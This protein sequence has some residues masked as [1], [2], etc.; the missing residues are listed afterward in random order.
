MQKNRVKAL[1][2]D[3]KSLKLGNRF[4]GFL[5]KCQSIFGQGPKGAGELK[6]LVLPSS[7][8][9]WEQTHS[10]HL[11]PRISITLIY[12]GKH[13]PKGTGKKTAY[14]FPSFSGMYYQ[15]TL[16]N[17]FANLF[18]TIVMLSSFTC[19]FD[20]MKQRIISNVQNVCRWL[21]HMNEDRLIHSG[22]VNNETERGFKTLC[23]KYK[24]CS[25]WP[26]KYYWV[27]YPRYWQC[28]Y[29]LLTRH[30]HG[31]FW[32]C[33]NELKLDFTLI[34]QF[35]LHVWLQLNRVNTGG[36]SCTIF[37]TVA[38]NLAA[39]QQTSNSHI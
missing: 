29:V 20:T 1:Y 11:T 25:F 7:R 28:L 6:R 32:M 16:L 5:R 4:R 23:R 9:Q 3:W 35:N 15:S 27:C 10:D 22:L 19:Q 17:T 36:D 34:V 30:A 8:R 39:T 37:G 14:E 26:M 13:I 38:T 12:F 18:I 24:R 2:Q 31:A 33:C 21:W